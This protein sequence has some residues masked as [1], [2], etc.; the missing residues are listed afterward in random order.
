MRFAILSLFLLGAC[1]REDAP[2]R[3]V[4]EA[5]APAQMT[6]VQRRIVDLPAGQR[7]AVLLRAILDG[8]APCQGVGEVERRPDANGAPNFLARCVDGPIYMIAVSPTGVA[9]VAKIGP[10]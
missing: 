7:D 8:G 10:R 6:S 1:G 9:Q 4:V 3:T 2:E 5:A